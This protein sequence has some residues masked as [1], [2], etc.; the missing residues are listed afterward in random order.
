MSLFGASAKQNKF[1]IQ[2]LSVVL[3]IC[4]Y[5]V[6]YFSICQEYSTQ[7]TTCAALVR[8]NLIKVP[9]TTVHTLE[10]LLNEPSGAEQLA[11]D[12]Q[13]SEY[14]S[15]KKSSTVLSAKKKEAKAVETADHQLTHNLG[16][17]WPAKLWDATFPTKKCKKG[18]LEK[19]KGQKELG[20]IRD[21]CHGEPPG[22][23]TLS[24]NRTQATHKTTDLGVSYTADGDEDLDEIVN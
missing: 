12:N 13:V 15:G 7:C 16:V 17:W 6:T 21:K 3:C 9:G 22:T 4:V 2:H 24:N 10:G 5:M 18:E 20:V 19:L 1:I 14:E 8:R 11:W 23:V